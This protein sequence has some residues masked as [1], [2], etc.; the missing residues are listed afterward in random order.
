MLWFGHNSTVVGENFEF[1]FS[2]MLKNTNNANISNLEFGHENFNLTFQ[3]LLLKEVH[4]L[5]WVP[6]FKKFF[7]APPF[8]S[9]PKF[10]SPPLKGGRQTMVTEPNFWKKSWGSPIGETSIFGSF[11]IFLSISLDQVMKSFWNF[12]NIISSTLSNT[13]WKTACPG[14]IWSGCLMASAPPK[15]LRGDLENFQKLGR[16]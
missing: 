9:E 14:E 10:S 5:Y 8:V 12:I 1:C 2:W 6:P 4:L 3:A 15:Y 16:G 13:Y 11:L 7:L